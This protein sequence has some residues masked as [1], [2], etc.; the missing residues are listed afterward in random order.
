MAAH[1]LGSDGISVY[2]G[3]DKIFLLSILD[4]NR[5]PFNLLGST[6]TM[7]VR[8]EICDNRVTFTKVST[9]A[10]EIEVRSPTTLGQA[11]VKILD[12]DTE[13]LPHGTYA[14]DIWVVLPS[15]REKVVISPSAFEIKPPI[16]EV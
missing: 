12:T 7:T 14:Y 13:D 2:K 4:G 11:Y 5:N 10:A 6:I 9:D 1:S 3:E 8:P 16:R 15:G